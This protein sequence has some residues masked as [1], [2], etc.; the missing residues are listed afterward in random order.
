MS[1]WRVWGGSPLEGSTV[2]AGSERAALAALA[3]CPLAGGEIELTNVPDTERTEQ[4]LAALRS[5]GCRTERREDVVDVDSRAAARAVPEALA[6]LLGGTEQAL[7]AACAAGSGTVRDASREP[8]SVHFMDFLRALGARLDGAGTDRVT[9]RSFQPPERLGWRVMPDREDGAAALC[10]CAAAG[11]DIL[12]RG[13]E[14]AHLRPVTEAL[15]ALGAQAQEGSHRLRL[16]CAGRLRGGT[17]LIAGPWPALWQR[18]LPLLAAACLRAERETRLVGVYPGGEELGRALSRLGGRV[19]VQGR[20]STVTGV[21]SLAGA[22][23]TARDSTEAR[24]LLIA[25]LGASGRTDIAVSRHGE[26]GLMGLVRA[27]TDL[28]ARIETIQ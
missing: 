1:I 27:L 15:S 25:A 11:G 9:V 28:G 17:A 26:T 10:A 22:A 19:L 16:R 8:E 24:A 5:A 23:V 4:A 2:L 13:A 3:A 12:L 6:A 14:P 18:A 21:D 20:V 7:L